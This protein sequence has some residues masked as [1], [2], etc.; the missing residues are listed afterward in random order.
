MHTFGLLDVVDPFWLCG[1]GVL[2]DITSLARGLQGGEDE[3]PG[4]SETVQ[5]ILPSH[6]LL[7]ASC[8]VADTICLGTELLVILFGGIIVRLFGFLQP[9]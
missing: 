8:G 1:D 2:S 5:V 9:Y 4:M 6:I 3:V 7:F